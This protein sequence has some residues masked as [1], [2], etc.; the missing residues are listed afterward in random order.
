[1]HQTNELLKKLYQGP[2]KESEQ[3]PKG[4]SP[5]TWLEIWTRLEATKLIWEELDS[6]TSEY[7]RISLDG[8][9]YH[10]LLRG[11]EGADNWKKSKADFTLGA[12]KELCKRPVKH[13]SHQLYL[14]SKDQKASKEAIER[15]RQERKLK[16][17]I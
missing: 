13:Q 11:C 9:D 17:G 15:F 4:I 10:D 7:W 5:S 3:Q 8:Y 16:T 12:F 6:S 1:M 2:T 14:P